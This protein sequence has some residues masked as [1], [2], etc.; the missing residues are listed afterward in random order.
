MI[1]RERISAGV[2]GLLVLSPLLAVPGSG[3][4][5]V[6]LPVVAVLA[7]VLLAVPGPRRSG[8]VFW[9]G[10]LF[11]AVQLVSL[12]ASRSP[13]EGAAPVLVLAAGLA[14]YAAVPER[15][16]AALLL[17]ALGAVVAG[18]GLVQAAMGMPAVSTQGNTN[19]AGTLAA[20]L[21][22]VAAVS[23][24]GAPVPRRIL[25]AASAAL[26]VV[27]LALTGS[28]AGMLGAGAGLAVA[29]PLALGRRRLLAGAAV[30]VPLAVL[31]AGAVL[32]GGD[33]ARVRTGA[34]KGAGAMVLDRP[35]FGVGPGHFDVEYPPYRPEEEAVLSNRN[36]GGGWVE[37]EDPHSVPVQV[38]VET[39]FV[40]LAAF[41]AVVV[42]AFRAALRAPD[43]SLRAGMVGGMTAFLVAGLFNTLTFHV[44]H[45][46]LFWMMAAWSAPPGER[47]PA[48]RLG[49]SLAGAAALA[50]GA[51]IGWRLAVEDRAWYHG[52][53]TADA[54]ERRARLEPAA[55]AAPWSWRLRYGLAGAL[56]AGGRPEKAVERYEEALELRPHH[57]GIRNDL[58]IAYLR[59]NRSGEARRLL[60]ESLEKSPH[61][62]LMHL[63]LGTMELE[64]GDAAAARRRLDRALELGDRPRA[65]YLRGVAELGADGEAARGWFRRAAERGFDVGTALR[66]ERPAA[67]QDPLF[68]EFFP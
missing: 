18:V 26:L 44:S 48:V 61:F 9:A 36:A 58:A 54:E 19:Y 49:L 7:A 32:A 17:P 21:L 1:P 45:A 16:Q 52:M 62:D 27:F 4:D 39:G 23:V 35:V 53:A 59:S 40:G 30:A 3:Y 67:S 60:E 15:F 24:R 6:R 2:T 50:L 5:A 8:P 47:S 37:V 65:L 43:A 25:S 33:S 14:A 20:L 11:L 51:W 55:E 68:R 64:R 42:L 57:A 63:T 22:P 13:W 29:V 31:A 46:L 28:R 41:L 10:L 34:W 66:R 56:A 12:S 38:A